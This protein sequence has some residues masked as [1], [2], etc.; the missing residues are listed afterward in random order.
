MS[1]GMIRAHVAAKGLAV[2][3]TIADNDPRMAGRTLRI[4]DFFAMSGGVYARCGLARGNASRMVEI[5]LDR[6]HTDGKE[7]RTG[8]S[9]VKPAASNKST[10]A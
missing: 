10:E 6:I 5:R 4:Q 2:G 7:R 8:F 3:N 9:L 1:T